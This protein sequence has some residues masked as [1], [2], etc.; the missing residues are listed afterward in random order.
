MF[1]TRDDA[2]GLGPTL[3]EAAV[4]AAV[5]A[6]GA[7]APARN[8][9]QARALRLA[10][11]AAAFHPY[12]VVRHRVRELLVGSVGQVGA[13]RL[14]A[15]VLDLFAFRGEPFVPLRDLAHHLWAERAPEMMRRRLAALGPA[16]PPV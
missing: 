16:L 13:S 9:P 7:S 12:G 8:A 10:L 14:R 15:E 2:R 4:Q 11:A 5:Q 1:C 6:A 3:S